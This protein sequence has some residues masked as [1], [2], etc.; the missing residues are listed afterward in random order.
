[1]NDVKPLK[2]I[3]IKEELV[4]LTG[5]F[6]KAIVLN[7]FL[8][9]QERVEDF[10]KLIEEQKRRA[11]NEGI[12]INMPE[13]NG[14]IYKTAEEL[15][16]ETMLG[17]SPQTVRRI[18]KSLVENGWLQERCNPEFKWDKTLQYRINFHKLIDDLKE[19]GYHLDGYMEYCK[20]NYSDGQNNG[21]KP[22][23]PHGYR[24]SKMEIRSSNRE[25]SNFQN[26][27]S[28]FQNGGA[29][30][31]ITTENIYNQSVSHNTIHRSMR[32]ICN[33]GIGNN[34]RQTDGR[35]ESFFDMEHWEE[36]KEQISFTDFDEE[37]QVVIETAITGL[38][39]GDYDRKKP[40]KIIASMLDKMDAFSV[41]RALDSYRK[42]DPKE[43]IINPI[44]YFQQCLLNAAADDKLETR[45]FK[46]R[47][48]SS[49]TDDTS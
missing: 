3:V 48:I 11:S 35:T 22:A 10:D 29:I 23:N 14:W 15:S 30:P 49:T 20:K 6:K 17:M 31:E 43:R 46:Q 7:Q 28:I 47:Y 39:A 13:Q 32:D 33:N 45:R 27:G 25:T 12:E 42:T 37:D 18:I 5:D 16:E 38:L 9:W 40:R 24:I 44:R 21:E 34:D 4:A 41:E 36:I 1:M 26:G 19:I 8:Y 2:R